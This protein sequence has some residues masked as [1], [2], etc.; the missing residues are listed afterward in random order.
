MIVLGAS[1][2]KDDRVLLAVSLGFW[3]EQDLI[4][5]TAVNGWRA[6]GAGTEG[7]CDLRLD[8]QGSL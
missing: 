2:A 3:W 6:T 1:H 4:T 5:L 7:G 8:G